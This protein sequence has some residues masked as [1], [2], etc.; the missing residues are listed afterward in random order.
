M[1][2]FLGSHAINMDAKGR[3]AIPAKVREEF[4]H[5]GGSRVVLTAN[6]ADDESERCILLYPE[7]QWAEVR[8]QID[9]LPNMSRAVRRLQRLMLGH[10]VA[11]DFDAAGRILIPPTLRRHAHL[12]K[13]L[14]L[15]GQ[16][17]KLE[18]WSEER[19]NDWLD[20]SGDGDDIPPEMQALSL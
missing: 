13:K 20:G 6:A 17:K 14:M 5:A 1:G 3:L 2:N 7:A 16:G 19:W 11:A 12:E 10:A 9:G 4:S 8:A 18:L 15:I